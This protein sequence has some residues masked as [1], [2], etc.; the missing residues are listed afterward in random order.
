MSW[1]PANTTD[2]CAKNSSLSMCQPQVLTFINFLVQALGYSYD[3]LYSDRKK[4][5]SKQNHFSDEYDFI[6]VGAGS[7]GCVLANRLS[8]VK[9]WK[10]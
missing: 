7:A 6:I 9:D 4:G 5:K 3:K 10:V 1:L 8:E 2:I